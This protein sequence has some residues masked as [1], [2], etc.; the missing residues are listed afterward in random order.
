MPKLTNKS[1]ENALSVEEI[2]KLIK[3]VA[4]GGEIVGEDEE[5]I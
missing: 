5:N 1:T 2:F 3:S 4:D